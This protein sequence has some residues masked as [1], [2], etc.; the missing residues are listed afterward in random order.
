MTIN[1][2]SFAHISDRFRLTWHWRKARKIVEAS[3]YEITSITTL[4]DCK[5]PMF[6][7]K[8]FMI[9]HYTQINTHWNGMNI[10]NDF[11]HQANESNRRY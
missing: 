5:L 10:Q 2:L 7:F 3:M 4:V 8:T 6:N 9:L 11:T 1:E